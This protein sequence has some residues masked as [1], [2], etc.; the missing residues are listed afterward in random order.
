MPFSLIGFD[1][2]SST[3]KSFY[4]VKEDVTEDIS[5]ETRRGGDN[6]LFSNQRSAKAAVSLDMDFITQAEYGDLMRFYSNSFY[7]GR[8]YLREPASSL[9]RIIFSSASWPK[10]YYLE[11][12]NRYPTLGAVN[13]GKVDF[14]AGDKTVL[15]GYSGSVLYTSTTYDYMHFIL[16]VPLKLWLEGNYGTVTL[17]SYDLLTRVTTV[18]QKLR[19]YNNIGNVGFTVDYY[20]FAKTVWTEVK[21]Q[22]LTADIDNMVGFGLRPV[23]G[24][25]KFQDYEDKTIFG[26][27]DNPVMMFKITPNQ[28]RPS[29]G[30]TT[31]SCKHMEFA[32]NG[33]FV[34]QAENFNY[35]W[36]DAITLQ[37][38]MGQMKLLEI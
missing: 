5:F 20:N 9:Q 3:L 4:S 27:A 21:R 28:A 14:S 36:R 18:I 19:A 29:S 32:I 34:K 22:S 26:D 30:T 8:L 17:G 33:Y 31:L 37:G 23:V 7:T 38:Y 25:S 1:A 11:S 6:A 24:F 16:I 2:V 10:G 13:S 35:N 12:N 15:A